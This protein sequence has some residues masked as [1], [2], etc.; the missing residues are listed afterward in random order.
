MPDK[1]L[2]IHNALVCTFGE[3]NQVVEDGAVW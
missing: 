1:P 2:I 3:A